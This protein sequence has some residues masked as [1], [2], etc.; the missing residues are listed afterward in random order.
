MAGMSGLRK[1]LKG[2][3]ELS[4]GEV[5]GVGA[6]FVRYLIL[7]RLLGSANFG[8]AATFALTIQILQ[9]MSNMALNMLIVQS[10]HGDD[11]ALQATAHALQVC[12]GLINAA[13]I[14][15]LAGP[16]SALFGIPEARWAFQWLAL[17]P[18][19]EGFIHFDANRMEREM[20][21]RPGIAVAVIPKVLTALAAWPM[22]AWR[23]DYSAMLWLLVLQ[24]ATTVLLSHILATRRYSLAWDK[25]YLTEIL[26]FG[27]PLLLNGMLVFGV[28]QGDRLIVGTLYTMGDLGVYSVSAGLVMTLSGALFKV[29]HTVMLPSL[30]RAQENA[31]EFAR[32]Y[33]VCALM[34]S[35]IAALYGPVLIVAGQPIIVLA[36]GEQYRAA[37]LLVGWL[38]AAQ[39]IRVLRLGPSLAAM[40]KGDTRCLM[41][42]NICRM[43]GVAA[44][45]LAGFVRADLSWIAA[46]AV[47]GE[48]V[49]FPVPIV[50]LSRRHNLRIGI[51]LRPG[52]AAMATMVLSG[53]LVAVGAREVTIAFALLLLLAGALCVAFWAVFAFSSFRRTL[54]RARAL[55]RPEMDD[56]T[57][58]NADGI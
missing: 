53:L 5:V 10:K 49:A 51:C 7:A 37:G 3:T 16:I 6:N 38:A 22:V 30:S 34:F 9:T 20:R 33:R 43:S 12:R 8:I 13:L 11:R 52:L 14:L 21:F 15:G 36:Y 18:L 25:T 46:A 27:W 50:R 57:G 32:R 31:E 24:G 2:T 40:A 1:T 48:V 28:F 26:G 39:A 41:Y 55:L 56:G 29:I 58:E 4:M 54:R 17:V 23:G 35:F 42:A 19:L 44:A 45:L 47:I